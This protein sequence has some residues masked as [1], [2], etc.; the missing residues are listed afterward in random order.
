MRN[1]TIFI[2]IE[3]EPLLH[4]VFPVPLIFSSICIVENTIAFSNTIRPVA[5]ITIPQ[6]FSLP[7]WLKP[8]MDTPAVLV[9]IVPLAKIFLP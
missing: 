2:R 9:V 3:S 4:V 1:F 5:F 8:N 7:F 6:V